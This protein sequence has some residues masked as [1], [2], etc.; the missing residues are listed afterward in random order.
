M[1]NV[2]ITGTLVCLF[3]G[4]VIAGGNGAVKAPLLNTDT[5]MEAGSIVANVTAKP[6]GKANIEISLKAGKSETTYDILILLQGVPL[7]SPSGT[8]STNKNGHGNAK[9]VVTSEDVDNAGGI[10]IGDTVDIT[11]QLWD[12][13]ELKFEGT[14][15]GV[16]VPIE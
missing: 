14:A 16:V 5:Q 3:A 15:P 4:F 6:T 8:L 1:K 7:D 13:T 12:D 9:V 2:M 10:E 11:V